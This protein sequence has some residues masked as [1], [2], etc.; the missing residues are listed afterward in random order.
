MW[1]GVDDVDGVDGVDGVDDVD[2]VDRVDD[3]DEVDSVD[4]VDDVDEVDRVDGVDGIDAVDAGVAGMLL[5]AIGGG[6]R[7]RPSPPAGTP[8]S[9]PVHPVHSRPLRTPRPPR[10]KGLITGK[11]HVG[12]GLVSSFVRKEGRDGCGLPWRSR[13]RL[14]RNR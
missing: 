7:R 13:R 14:P 8:L 12:H 10:K 4:G 11:R 3:V 6:E 2:E 1:T 5:D 9:T